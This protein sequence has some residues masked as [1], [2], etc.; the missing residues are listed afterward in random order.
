MTGDPDRKNLLEN[1]SD[2][3]DRAKEDSITDLPELFGENK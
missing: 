2:A 3:A 1:L